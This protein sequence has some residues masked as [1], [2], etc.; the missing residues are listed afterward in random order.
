MMARGAREAEGREDGEEV[1]RGWK[2]VY[3]NFLG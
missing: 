3:P 1:G 2:L